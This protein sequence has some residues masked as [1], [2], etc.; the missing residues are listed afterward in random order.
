VPSLLT[1]RSIARNSE[2]G[3]TPPGR[4]SVSPMGVPEDTQNLRSIRGRIGAYESWARTGDRSARTWPGRKAALDRF[5]REVDPEGVLSQ[6]E[7]TKRAEWAHKAH[8]QRLA[9]KSVAAR[10]RRKLVCQTCGQPKEAAAPVCSE[11]LNKLH[12]P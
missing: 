10:Q 3:S 11:C 5:E 12:E 7:R 8:M 1:K 2:V 6:Q 4:F 9:L